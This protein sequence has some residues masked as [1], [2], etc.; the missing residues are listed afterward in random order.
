MNES[1]C[2][3]LNIPERLS[4]IILRKIGNQ[5]GPQFEEIKME[6]KLEKKIMKIEQSDDITSLLIK[7]K[8]SISDNLTFINCLETLQKIIE[9]ILRYPFDEKYRCIRL[10]NK[11][12]LEKIKPYDYAIEIL[13]KVNCLFL[14][15]IFIIQPLY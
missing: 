14:L 6:P 15:I 1:V 11:I 8:K 7:L 10:T 5:A 13:K 3:K 2:Q 12:F 9:N 4:Q